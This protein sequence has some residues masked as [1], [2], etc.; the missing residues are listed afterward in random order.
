MPLNKDIQHNDKAT[1][2][3]CTLGKRPIVQGKGSGTNGFMVILEAPDAEEAKNNVCCA[4]KNGKRL[5]QL[6]DF[7]HV[8]VK[9]SRVTYLCLCNPPG[10]RPVKS[11]EITHCAPR[12]RAEIL[13]YKPHTIFLLGKFVVKA[14]LGADY[15]LKRYHGK[16]I[17][18]DDVFYIPMFDPIKAVENFD[19]FTLLI[20]D[21]RAVPSQKA[22]QQIRGEY[23]MSRTP[24]DFSVAANYAS[25]D[26]E[27]HGF[28]G[29]VIGGASA[30]SAGKASFNSAHVL[31]KAMKAYSC[32][33]V[34]HNANFDVGKLLDME[35]KVRAES[36][37]DTMMLAYV[38][39]YA[40][41]GLKTLVTQELSLDYP[42]L[43]S[44]M[45]GLPLSEIATY[46]CQDA[47]ATIRLWYHLIA[48]AEI[49]ELNLYKKIEQPLIMP[50]LL[51]EREG[52]QVDQAKVATWDASLQKEVKTYLDV[53]AEFGLTEECI[54]KPRQLG[55]WLKQ[56][57]IKMPITEKSQQISTAKRELAKHK[58]EH[59]AIAPLLEYK[60]VMKLIST[61]VRPLK[62]DLD[63]DG[64]M[65]S[66]YLQARVVTGRLSSTEP[67]L[68]NLPYDKEARGCYVAKKGHVFG[69][70]DYSQI[71][72]RILAAI[73]GDKHLKEAYA[74]GDDVH[75]WVSDL[76]FGD[77]N[78]EH[79]HIVKGAHYCIVYGG[80]AR[81]LYTQMSAPSG[82]ATLGAYRSELTYERCQ[83]IIVQYYELM[84]GVKDWQDS[85]KERA[86]KYG[87]VDDWYG[88]RRYLP[89]VNA[90]DRKTREMAL[91]KA[92]NFPIAA[93]AG[94]IFK[95]SLIATAPIWTAIQ[96]IHDE[97]IFELPIDTADEI[98]QRLSDAMRQV[99][100]PCPLVVEYKKGHSLADLM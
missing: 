93:P 65:H 90:P 64:R 84:T 69:S 14:L 73:S 36:I 11:K 78:K 66:H 54:S 33:L 98:A 42:D 48:E 74:T 76:M 50:L 70:I 38:M 31:E 4:G 27:S 25:L 29:A 100:A 96:N 97:L 9:A 44:K 59:S 52:I 68:Q 86:S 16:V 21:F 77:H 82:A 60:R 32:N 80:G 39:N 58:D 43:G 12:L 5:T 62:E 22:V 85:I 41:L 87:Y 28:K 47:D 7:A 99:E 19:F 17:E 10:D 6:L 89:G 23:G 67:N 91:R 83:E 88:R 56:Q 18:R 8:D 34:F 61:Y 63:E 2:G 57:K 37:D 92:I 1:C 24:L 81:T 13:R 55:K 72:M 26:L 45:E 20:R 79:R 46:C 71:D 94:S 15:G 51:M 53:L 30:R 95:L 49:R 40:S 75:G 35:V 3:Q